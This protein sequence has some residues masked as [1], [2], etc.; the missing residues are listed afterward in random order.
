MKFFGGLLGVALCNRLAQRKQFR[1][2]I[3]FKTKGKRSSK[4]IGRGGKGIAEFDC[5][6]GDRVVCPGNDGS[7]SSFSMTSL[8]QTK[9]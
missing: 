5:H 3:P 4:S 9:A 1:P 6:A 8:Q 2:P 7:L